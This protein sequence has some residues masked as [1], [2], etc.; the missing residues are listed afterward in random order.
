[1]RLLFTLLALL[2]SVAL[3]D[4]LSP[5]VTDGCSSF[6]DGTYHEQNLW[7][8]CCVAHDYAYWKG[9]TYSERLA[10]DNE[11]ERCVSAVGEPAIAQVMLI[12]VRLGGTPFSPAGF[13]WGYGWPYPRGYRALSEEE[14]Q[15]I[16]A[17][18]S[19]L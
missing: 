17:A 3:A 15:Q 12:G 10:A 18:E 4:A 19:D 13:R 5:F 9:G 7:L 6:P 16:N 11:L 1:M 2:P 14:L 8:A